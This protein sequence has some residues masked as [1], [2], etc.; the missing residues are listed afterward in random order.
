MS[1]LWA[2]VP[3]VV[4]LVGFFI[5]LTMGDK[6]GRIKPMSKQRRVGQ[7]PTHLVL[8]T[9]RQAVIRDQERRRSA[10]ALPHDARQPR[11]TTRQQ[12]REE[13]R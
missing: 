8:T 11:S 6:P 12:L 3:L 2:T 5:W 4:F 9:D 1:H 10:C 13:N 7:R